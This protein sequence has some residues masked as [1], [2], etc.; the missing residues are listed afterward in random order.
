VPT[1]HERSGGQKIFLPQARQSWVVIDEG[2]LV[3]TEYQGNNFNQ[4]RPEI[5]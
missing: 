1:S 4:G 3:K 2:Q 5:I